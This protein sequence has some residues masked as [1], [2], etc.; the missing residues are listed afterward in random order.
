MSK[1][2]VS[3]ITDGTTTVGTNYVVNGSAKVW[4]RYD[5]DSVIVESFNVSSTADSSTAGLTTVNI[6]NAFDSAGYAIQGTCNGTSADRFV[7]VSSITSTSYKTY[8]FDGS[9]RTDLPVGTIATGD[10]A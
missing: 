4:A 5:G 1:L 10:L 2:N 7:T 8:A 3:N 9:V 6:T